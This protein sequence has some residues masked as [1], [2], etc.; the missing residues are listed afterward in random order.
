MYFVSQTIIHKITCLSLIILLA[1]FL[2]ISPSKAQNIANPSGLKLPRF[3]STHS[4]PINVRVG[5]GKKYD[6]AWI[7]VKSNI[8]V[9][10]IR[11][12][13]V[14]RKIRDFEGEEGWVHQSLLSGKRLGRVNIS[15]GE[16]VALYAKPDK[17][18]K[19]RAHIGAKYPLE[20]KKCN[21][22]WCEVKIKYKNPDNKEIS[23]DGYISQD[24][25]WGVYEGEIFD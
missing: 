15:E 21:S 12:F 14:W 22:V 16:Q 4:S 13:D 19:I 5:P 25:V 6:V 3:A 11:E 9:E 24:V 8:P 1:V 20:L 17:G 7:F 18:A 10:I 23:I 2:I